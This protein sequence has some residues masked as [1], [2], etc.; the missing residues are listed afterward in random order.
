MLLVPF[1]FQGNV[2]KTF[3]GEADLTATHLLNHVL[4]RV[5]DSKS[6]YDVFS[7]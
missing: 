1:F 6:P 2:P 5:L 7:H 4:S 3:L